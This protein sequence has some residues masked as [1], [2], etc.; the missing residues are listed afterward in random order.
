MALVVFRRIE[1]L[2]I[3]SQALSISTDLAFQLGKMFVKKVV[4]ASQEERG[5]IH[6]VSAVIQL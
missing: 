3:E 4:D 2:T 6:Q 1:L 5:Y